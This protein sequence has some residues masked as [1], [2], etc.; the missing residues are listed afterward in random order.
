[1]NVSLKSNDAVSGIVKL[2]IEKKD[3]ESRVENSL[4]KYRRQANMPGFRKGMIPMSMVKKMYGKYILSEEI[5]KIV[6]EGLTDYLQ[7]NEVK[8]LGEPFPNE[9]EQP[10][11][12]FDTQESFEFYFD[13][14]FVPTI[15]LE[16]STNDSLPFYE[17][18]IDDEMVNQRISSFRKN[19]GSYEKVNEIEELD[20]V[21]GVITE[22]ENG[23]PKPDG[24]VVERGVLM[25]KYFKEDEEKQKFLGKSPG[26]VVFFNPYKAYQGAEAEMIS[27]LDIPK[28][29]IPEALVDFSFEITEITRHQEAK[30]DQDLF[31]KVF[32]KDDEIKDEDEFLEKIKGILQEELRLESE[33]KFR[34]DARELLHS[35][36]VDVQ[37]AEPIVKRWFLQADANLTPEKCEAEFP[38]ILKDV[39]MHL[40]R[41]QLIKQNDLKI[42]FEDIENVA[43]MHVKNLFA[44]YGMPHV[45]A[46]L[47]NDYVQKQL[48]KEDMRSQFYTQASEDVVMEWLK[49][50]ISI[51][52]KAITHEAFEKLFDLA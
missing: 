48:Q 49:T 44:Q 46:E 23:V 20:M 22:L 39:K 47:L 51:E 28:E 33:Y 29:S 12:D 3:Y 25:V 4:R 11:I 32:G 18:E 30:L 8:I 6:R 27:L 52:P 19:Y 40:C 36:L 7:T 24:I 26:D 2:E 35:K 9:T 42:Q 43:K 50:Q 10:T 16:L 41:E 38:T 34:Q 45:P 31:K 17:Q 13:I 1:M 5:E 15:Q 37:L 21:K 14:A